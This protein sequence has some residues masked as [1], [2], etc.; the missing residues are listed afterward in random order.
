M[1]NKPGRLDYRTPEKKPTHVA[2]P[3]VTF[4]PPL[5]PRRGLFVALLGV[6]A[7]WVGV[8]LTMYFVTVYPNRHHHEERGDAVKKPSP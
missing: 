4:K 2:P 6:F 8:L 3:G 1:K 5:K 7:V